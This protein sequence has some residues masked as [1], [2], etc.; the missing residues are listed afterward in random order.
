MVFIGRRSDGDMIMVQ[1][2]LQHIYI[3]FCGFQFLD[4]GATPL[5]SLC[6]SFQK[7]KG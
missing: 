2:G 1:V 4:S 7:V 5:D 6:F 3:Y